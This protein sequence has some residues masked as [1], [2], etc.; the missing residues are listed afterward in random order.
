MQK[1]TTVSKG[2]LSVSLIIDKISDITGFIAGLSMFLVAIFMIYEVVM[3]SFFNLPTTWVFPTSLFV[4]VWFSFLTIPLTVKQGRQ[5][6]ADFLITLLSER[7]GTMLRIITQ[8]VSLFF[9]SAMG[10]FGFKMAM[11]A[12]LNNTVSTDLLTYPLWLLYVIF[13]LSTILIGLQLVKCISCDINQLRNNQLASKPGLKDN[14]FFVLTLFIALVIVGLYLVKVAPIV[15]VIFL[16]L[17]SLII[18]SFRFNQ[19]DI[20]TE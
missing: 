1:N 3:R 5:I 15:G 10:Y 17:L 8:I 13:P 14:P 6:T 4:L 16:T 2:K 20:T 12:Y 11:K 7:T 9:V 19:G 18:S